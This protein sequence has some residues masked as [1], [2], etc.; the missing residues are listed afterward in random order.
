[1]E[2]GLVSVTFRKETYE[3]VLDYCVGSGLS[4]VEWGSDI[5]VPAGDMERARA[6]KEASDRAGVRICSYGSYYQLG[7]YEDVVAVFRPYL[8]TALVLG[9]PIIRV[10]AGKIGSA[11]ATEEYYERIVEEM[12]RLCDMTEPHQITL[13]F[14]FHKNTLADTAD[15]A[16]WLCREID[17]KNFGMYYQ[18][19]PENS[20]EENCATLEKLM[21]YLKM[22]HVFYYENRMKKSLQDEGGVDFWTRIIGRIKEEQVQVN[23]LLEFLK[24][25]SLEG[26]KREADVLKKLL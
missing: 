3:T 4:C 17:R 16:L 19:K 22:V 11:D 1:M 15:S 25:S 8:E 26:L 21:P 14:E 2:A 10:W 24:D 18:Q 12:K 7:E 6:V 20:P 5:H 13:A 9:A 23:L